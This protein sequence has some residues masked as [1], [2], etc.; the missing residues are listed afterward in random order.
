MILLQFNNH[1]VLINPSVR[2]ENS[3]DSPT[4]PDQVTNQNVVFS[5]IFLTAKLVIMM[6]NINT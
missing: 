5:F 1:F 2:S 3:T 4:L 6:K